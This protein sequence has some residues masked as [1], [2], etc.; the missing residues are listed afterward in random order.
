MDPTNTKK[1]IVV[2][3]AKHTGKTSLLRGLCGKEI[4]EE[5][6]STL[7][8][9]KFGD[10]EDVTLWDAPGNFPL[11]ILYTYPSVSGYGSYTEQYIEQNHLCAFDY[12]IL[13]TASRWVTADQ[14]LVKSAT[15]WHIPVL[16]VR[17]KAEEDVDG[18]MRRTNERYSEAFSRMSKAVAAGINNTLAK[19]HLEYREIFFISTWAIVDSHLDVKSTY[20]HDEEEFLI[21]LKKNCNC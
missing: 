14:D 17:N 1:Q 19:E 13:V 4:G 2:V 7:A 11:F 9:K 18:R 21:E 12:I 20:K 6:N 8:L 3:G 10:F 5:V 15:K 16:V